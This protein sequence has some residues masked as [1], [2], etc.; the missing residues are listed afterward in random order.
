MSCYITINIK[1]YAFGQPTL[2]DSLLLLFHNISFIC[3]GISGLFM[4]LF[5]NYVL[6][7][8]ICSELSGKLNQSILSTVIVAKLLYLS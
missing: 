8:Q 3:F 4:V 6:A 1:K 2:I 5:D 7:T